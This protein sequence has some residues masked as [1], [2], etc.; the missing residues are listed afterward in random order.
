MRNG[1]E[2]ERG[3]GVVYNR[4]NEDCAGN[5][6]LNILKLFSKAEKKPEKLVKSNCTLYLKIRLK[7][8]VFNI[9]HS[10]SHGS[11][12]I[13]TLILAYLSKKKKK[14]QYY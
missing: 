13:S 5:Y 10:T 9:V 7:A 1:S 11:V 14:N 8:F 3:T 2:S 4:E 6:S 12:C